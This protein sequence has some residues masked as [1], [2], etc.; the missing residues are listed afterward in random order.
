MQIPVP[1]CSHEDPHISVQSLRH[2]RTPQLCC[3]L[4]D[5]K[6]KWRHC[7]TYKELHPPYVAP[8]MAQDRAMD[9]INTIHRVELT[10]SLTKCSALQWQGSFD[11]KHGAWF[12]MQHLGEQTFLT[13][14]K[15]FGL[16]IRCGLTK[17][18]LKLPFSYG[19]RSSLTWT[20]PPSQSQRAK[21][22]QKRNSHGKPS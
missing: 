17:L 12:L 22:K 15:G 1:C 18:S 14:G 6:Q 7:P 2:S 9:I 19:F 5:T 16:Q 8:T 11:R 13:L 4:L 10:V 3:H 20:L 21:G